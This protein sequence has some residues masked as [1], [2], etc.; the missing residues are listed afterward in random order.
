M[1]ISLTTDKNNI[2]EKDEIW[3]TNIG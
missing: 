1:N 3:W 2:R